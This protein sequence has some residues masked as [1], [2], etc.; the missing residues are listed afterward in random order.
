MLY[1]W[2]RDYNPALGRYVESDPIGLA[3]GINAYAYV[4]DNLLA[5]VDPLGLW[6]ITLA[7]M[8]V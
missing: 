1:N 6:S 5:H 2:H 4:S 3:G 8:R 7:H